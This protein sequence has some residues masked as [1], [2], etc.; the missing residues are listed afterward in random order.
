MQKYVIIVAGGRGS[1]FK[2]EI[3]KQFVKLSGLP[4][5]MHTISAFF[6][7]QSSI[8]IIVVLP[9][10]QISY[11]KSICVDYKFNIQ[12]QITPG[13]STRFYSVKNGLSQIKNDGIVG[14][15]DGVRPLI[16]VETIERCYKMAGKEGNAIPV[17]APVDSMRKIADNGTNSYVDR[18]KYCLIQTPQVFKTELILKAFK[19]EYNDSFTDDASV[20]EAS[21]PGSINLVEGNRQNLKI[22]TPE[23]LLY[24][25][26]IIKSRIQGQ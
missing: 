1:R 15:H 14:I 20:L 9:E 21:I 6:T 16:D 2:S 26:A 11:W 13:G 5:L 17:V 4:V 3:P 7:Y 24:A 8:K 22:T 10:E 18:Q 23:D 19:Q 25:E 12:H